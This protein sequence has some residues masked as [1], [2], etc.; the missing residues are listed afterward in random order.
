MI[1]LRIGTVP[2]LNAAV[3]TDGLEEVPGVELGRVR[4]SGLADLLDKD[5]LDVALVP[6]ADFL[7]RESSW[8]AAAWYGISCCGPAWTVKIFSDTAL[9]R[10]SRLYV[11]AASHSSAA[12]ARVVFGEWV[13]HEV[14]YVTCEYDP[15]E[16]RSSNAWLLI[17]DK[18]LGGLPRRYVYDLGQIWY[19][20]TSLPFVFALWV[21]RSQRGELGEVDKLLGEL[22][23]R[24]HGRIDEL[25][26]RLG[27]AHGFSTDLAREYLGTIIRYRIGPRERAGLELFG[28]LLTKHGAERMSV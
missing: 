18:A 25:A 13:G 16:V 22:A 26:R 20:R 15:S 23:E 1:N 17:G 4:P 5:E 7:H 6:A 10:I 2:Y 24:N 11:D 21:C 9:D 3:L 27:P 12:L 28:R 19:E 8:E 14:E